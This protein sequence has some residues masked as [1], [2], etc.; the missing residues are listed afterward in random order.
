[1]RLFLDVLVVGKET[2]NYLS[3]NKSVF[4]IKDEMKKLQNRLE[5]AFTKTMETSGGY[6]MTDFQ[7]KNVLYNYMSQ[8]EDVLYM[9]QNECSQL[10]Q[11]AN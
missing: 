1:M 4:C 5:S 6:P 9:S 2:M 11:Y 3:N 7:G 10:K 8:N